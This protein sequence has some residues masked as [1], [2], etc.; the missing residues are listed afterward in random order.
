[1]IVVDATLGGA[2]HSREIVKR[3]SGGTL[4]G[5]DRD[6]TALQFSAKVLADVPNVEIRLIKCNF[7]DI[8]DVLRS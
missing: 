3:I 4:I 7:C 8:A 1:M 5:L 6:T 2:G